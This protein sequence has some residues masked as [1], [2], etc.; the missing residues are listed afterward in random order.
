MNMLLPEVGAPSASS[1]ADMAAQGGQTVAGLPILRE[2]WRIAMRRRW[3]ILSG[4]V[5]AVL[6]GLVATI[7]IT[8]KFTA[9]ATIEISRESDQVTEFQGVERETSIADQEFYQTQYGLLRARTLAERVAAELQLVND[10]E[11]FDMF[12]GAEDTPAFTL[13]NGRYNASGRADRLRQAGVIL[14]DNVSIE[15]T[16]LSS[17][18]DIA[19]TSPDPLFSAEVANSWAENFIESNLERKVQATAYGRDQLQRQLADYK[20][21][22]DESQRQLVAYATSEQIINL[23]S[24]V[25]GSGSDQG[26]SLVADNLSSLN[27]ALTDATA[28]RIQAEARY[29]QIGGAGA[30]AEA[31]ENVAINRLREERAKVSSE[32]QQLLVRF[33]PGYPAAEALKSR[34]DEIDRSLEREERRV[35]GSL[36]TAFRQA[37]ARER[38]L[39]AKV[40]QLKSDFLDLRRR[41]IQ[42][43]IYQQEVDT[44]SAL[45]DGLLQRFK[46]IGVAGGVGINNVAVVDPA[47]IP[48]EPSSPKLLLNLLISVLAGIG[49]G[50]V[51]ALI[52]EQMDEAFGDPAEVEALLNLP[53]LGSVPK[54]IAMD[55]KEALLDKKSDIV[56]AYLS[57]FTNL[58][59]TTEHGVPRTLSIT[60]TRPAEGKSTTSLAI[61][62][63]LARAGKRVILVDGDMR[64]P[65]VHQL[66]GVAN[67]RGLSNFLA[68]DNALEPL[69]FDFD[70]SDVMFKAMSAGPIPPNAAELLTGT[71]LALMLERLLESFD[72]V[73]IDSPP[74]MGLADAP[75]IA[76]QVEG[77]LYAIESHH[78]KAGIVKSALARLRASNT[79]ILG[80][81]LTKFDPKKSNYG[82]GYEYGYDYGQKAGEHPGG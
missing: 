59:F 61:A 19:M 77:V 5:A 75:I 16:R 54:S 15:P 9:V 18:V 63:S 4:V 42:Y 36:E 33:E 65:S 6:F 52:F 57:I 30:S 26:R 71:R 25:T 51:I 62:T 47:D 79:R 13:V 58:G 78:I 21:R 55:P 73:V 67:E 24:E 28:D 74:V 23:P 3:V 32:Y 82:Y 12:G 72:H 29:R 45:Y 40:G 37:S 1:T 53:L 38:Q 39:E 41:S 7:L 27:K 31:L 81:I 34:L 60:S 35:L 14:L 76:S 49:L 10:P 44:N 22:L 70:M 43:N 50:T 11:F 68:G 80:G 56:D 64:S 17:L 2:Y 20:E 46:E 48:Q 69:I 8:P 66:A